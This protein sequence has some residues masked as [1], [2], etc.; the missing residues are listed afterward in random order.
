METQKGDTQSRSQ[1]SSPFCLEIVWDDL[2]Q[3]LFARVHFDANLIYKMDPK[4]SY[5]NIYA[6]CLLYS[7]SQELILFQSGYKT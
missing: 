5:T 6:R 3:E 7:I 1:K 2:Q 4:S